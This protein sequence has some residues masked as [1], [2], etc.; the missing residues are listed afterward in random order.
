M[1]KII[2]RHVSRIPEFAETFREADHQMTIFI[3]ARLKK[4]S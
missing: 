4:L 1:G 2:E 3:E